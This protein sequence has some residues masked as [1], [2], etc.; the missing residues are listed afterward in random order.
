MRPESRLRLVSPPADPAAAAA[1]GELAARL[2]ADLGAALADEAA[3]SYEDLEAYVDGRMGADEAAAFAARVADDPLLAAEVE[4]LV[5]L[6]DR[7]SRARRPAGT[8][9]VWAAA[10]ALALAVAGTLSDGSGW[11]RPEVAGGGEPPVEARQAI[12]VDSFESG[13]LAAWRD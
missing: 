1:L 4:D 13:D 10:A 7:L 6:R 9:W 12:F 2:R 5:Q 8:R 11:R 3:P